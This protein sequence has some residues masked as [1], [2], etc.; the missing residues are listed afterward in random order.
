MIFLTEHKKA[1]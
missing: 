1:I